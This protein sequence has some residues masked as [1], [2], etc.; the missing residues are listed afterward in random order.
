M[1][2]HM[3]L[4]LKAA[5]ETKSTLKNK[6]GMKSQSQALGLGLGHSNV[7]QN[8]TA[9]QSRSQ[10]HGFETAHA[11]PHTFAFQSTHGLYHT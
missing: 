2:I 5:G 8:R 6:R 9:F 10:E 7:N 4:L 11:R 1:I 3:A